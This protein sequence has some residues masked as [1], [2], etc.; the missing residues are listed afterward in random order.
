MQHRTIKARFR[1]QSV[2]KGMAKIKQGAPALRT[3][4]TLIRGHHASF[5]F[6]GFNHGNGQGCGV[7]RNHR[8]AIGF[9][10]MPEFALQQPMLGHFRIASAQ[11]TR[12]QG[13]ERIRIGQHDPRLMKGAGEVLPGLQIH[14]GLAANTTIHL[15]Q[16]ACRDLHKRQAAHGNRRREARQIPHHTT[17]KRNHRRA[18]IHAGR[19]QIIQ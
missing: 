10:P 19:K 5:Q 14:P 17:A 4:L 2:S 18:P 1:F 11:F 12:R 6:A 15:G 13:A 7:P 9:A 8:L 16:Q 3:F